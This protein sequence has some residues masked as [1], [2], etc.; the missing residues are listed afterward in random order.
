MKALTDAE[1][2]EVTGGHV[3]PSGL[4]QYIKSLPFLGTIDCNVKSLTAGQWTEVVIVYTVGGS[5]LADGAWIKGTFKF[6]SDWALFQT[7]DR[8]KDNY[9]SAQYVPNERL[10]G[11]SEATVQ[12][13]YVRFDQKGH[14]RPFQ[15]AVIVDIVDGYI[16]PGDKI[17]LRLG[18]RRFGARGTRCQTFVEDKFLMRWYIDPVGTSRF[19]AIKPDVS[20]NIKS[21]PIHRLKVL[22]PRLVRPNVPFSVFAHSEDIWGNTTTDVPDYEANLEIWKDQAATAAVKASVPVSATG[23]T[24]AQFF[25]DGLLDE[26]DYTVV[27]QFKD[28]SP[29]TSHTA[30]EHITVEESS[31][32][33]R[34]LFGDLHV[35]SDDTVGTNDSAYNFSY[36]RKIAGLDVVGYTANDF[37][38][39]AKRW[40]STLGLIKEINTA[41]EFVVFPGTEWCGN[42]A[43]GG[44]HNV[45]FLDDPEVHPPEFPLD[46]N[47]NVARS[48]E[49]N[50]DGPAELRPG[51]WPLDEV[52]ATYAHAA[53]SHL[54][55]P[56]VGGRRC[57]LDWHHPQLDR[58]VEIGSAWGLFEWL[59]QDAVYRGLKVGVCAN[60]DEHRGRCGGGVPGTQVFG[61]KGG[62]TG[63]ISDSLERAAV[64]K[65]LRDRHTFATTGERLVGLLSAENGSIQGD[66]IQWPADTPLKLQYAFYC[67]E[68]FSSIEAFD[69]SGRVFER[70]L[71]LEDAAQQ[72]KGS[73]LRITWGGAR[74]YD[75]YREAVWDGTISIHGSSRIQSAEPFGGVS[76][77]PEEVIKQV[78]GNHV[79]FSTRTSGDFDGVNLR[80]AGAPPDW[81]SVKGTLGG[82]V[83]VGNVL[84]GNP[85]KAQPEFSFGTMWEEASAAGGQRFE[86]KGG[87]D[88]FVRVE[89]V[90][91]S[92][93][94][95]EARGTLNLKAMPKGT[96]RAVYGVG[97]EWDGGK[98]ITSPIFIEYV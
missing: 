16:N 78:D 82:Y 7:S 29:A 67:S 3:A 55:I 45:V 24:Y 56:H 6:Y 8:T 68:G 13:L 59:I 54:I 98:V 37:N 40:E 87:A 94:P 63:I 19:A 46:K 1:L 39:T 9:V 80:F 2:E 51:A 76:Y 72:S 88:L 25:V 28:G 53:E 57:N 36:A 18:D 23:W 83:K 69:A 70:D 41:G 61:T 93:L 75:R 42:S 20:I 10:P 71:W 49:W 11:Q 74:L 43:A 66:E 65:A 50:E 92:P 47:G 52:Y 4:Y 90:P 84:N 97:R 64:G 62:I 15:K 14:E 44:D 12:D 95:L 79:A 26:G 77:V 34:I 48:F 35:H 5:G 91:D 27:V 86:I 85:H 33:P 32:V 31:P 73:V 58:L 89:A 81:I 60:S 96:Q 22:T 17:V 21:G 38:I 30:I